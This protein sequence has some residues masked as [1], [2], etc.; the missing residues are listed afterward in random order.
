MAP[1]QKGQQ[2]FLHVAWGRPIWMHM[3]HT[4]I[5]ALE[6]TT[7]PVPRGS[8]PYEYNHIL[9]LHFEIIAAIPVPGASNPCKYNHILRL[10]LK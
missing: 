6:I 1:E 3:D 4:R 10:D 2:L 8:N 9:C 5:N 7:F